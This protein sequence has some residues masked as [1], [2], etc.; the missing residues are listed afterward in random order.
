MPLMSAREGGEL[1]Q[2]IRRCAELVGRLSDVQPTG[3]FKARAH[4]EIKQ[5]TAG[6]ERVNAILEKAVA[7]GHLT[8][9]QQRSLAGASERIAAALE[10]GA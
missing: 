8:S 9:A 4:P 1:A 10:K 3:R 6:F 7:A 5:V 2:A